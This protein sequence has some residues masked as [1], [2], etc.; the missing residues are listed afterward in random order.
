MQFLQSFLTQFSNEILKITC[1]DLTS[2]HK[3]YFSFIECKSLLLR[4]FIIHPPSMSAH[5]ILTTIS[6]IKMANERNKTKGRKVFQIHATSSGSLNS[7]LKV[8]YSHEVNLFDNVGLW[9]TH[10][11]IWLHLLR[12]HFDCHWRAMRN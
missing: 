7:Y 10:Q 3:S 9:I 12:R 8:T 11:V 5:H 2:W 4:V 1:K 6:P